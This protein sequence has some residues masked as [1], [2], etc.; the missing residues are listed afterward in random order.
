MDA[1]LSE[2]DIPIYV[3]IK[4][5]P[6]CTNESNIARMFSFNGTL[7]Y[8][9]NHCVPVM[10]VLA[11]PTESHLLFIVMPLLRAFNDPPLASIEEVIDFVDQIL[12]VH[13][14]L[15]SR[16]PSYNV[17]LSQGIEFM[18]LNGVAHRDITCS[19]IMMDGSAMYPDGFHPV[20]QHLDLSAK[21]EVVPMSRT[22][23]KPK[24][25]IIDF[26]GSVWFP[27]DMPAELRTA[28]GKHGADDEVPE[29]SQSVPYDPFKVDIFQF[30]NVIKKEFLEARLPSLQPLTSMLTESLRNMSGL[31]S[32]SLSSAT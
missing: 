12:Q 6:S 4:A 24:Y 11:S 23:S 14:S 31:S 2:G 9:Q 13:G 1:T 28:T 16:M 3:I 19:N 7:D 17:H 18:H 25:Y 10:D 20:R 30:G 32:W 15:S 27:A 29:M 26:D 22:M 21:I 8:P 5:V